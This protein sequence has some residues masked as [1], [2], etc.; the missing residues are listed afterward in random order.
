MTQKTKK[1]A[2]P[3]I[4]FYRRA[5]VRWGAG[6]F[7]VLAVSVLLAFRLSPWPGALVIRAVFDD[8][9]AKTKQALQKHAPPGIS[10]LA[11][12]QYSRSDK[13]AYLDVYYPVKT[14]N[15]AHLPT[16]V[17]T[18]GGGWLSGD[19]T[20]TEPYFRLLASKGFTVVSLNYSLAPGRSYPTQ[21]HQLN[22]AHKYIQENAERFYVDT[23]KIYLAGDSAGAQLSAQM[24]TLITNPAYAQEVGL[25]PALKAS[26][27]RGVVLNCGIYKMEGLANPTPT[28][29]KI[30]GWG[31]D[32]TVWSYAGTHD[33]GSPRIRQ[34]SPYYHVTK[35]FPATF[36]TGGNDD[37]LTDAQ[38]KPLAD[39][40][41]SLGV[42]VDSLFYASDHQPG[43]PHEY[44][45]NLDTTDGQK[46]FDRIVDFLHR[47]T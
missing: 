24:A 22:Q 17:W 3:K 26:Q 28:L 25:T 13:A 36:I 15:G 21:I 5:G 18:H 14:V 6:G 16:V 45:F 29:P 42:T 34:M 44:Q 8:G 2:T 10:K 30:V 31:D 33:F 35:D 4:P 41:E 37:P 9:G 1:H 47:D 40:L 23:T 46:A 43:L 38:S 27:L 32:V 7:L 19:K 12:Q 20:N 39:K 11:D